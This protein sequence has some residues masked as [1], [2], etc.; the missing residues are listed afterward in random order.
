M[1]KSKVQCQERISRYKGFSLIELLIVVAIILIIAGIAIPNLLRARIAA[2][3]S[4]A[5]ESV[6]QIATA[7]IAYNAAYPTDGYATNLSSLGGPAAACA[8]SSTTA[9]FLD[10]VVSAGSKSG[11]TFFAA[12]FSIGGGPNSSFV[13]SSAPQSFNQT[14]VRDFC[15]TTDGVMHINPG[16]AGTVPAPDVA[17]C[18]GYSIAQ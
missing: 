5:A 4:S 14:G 17:T 18:S 16:A 9:C 1:C 7:E 3:E 15:I 6:R 12:G 8:P 10:S 11:Y 2:N 13:A